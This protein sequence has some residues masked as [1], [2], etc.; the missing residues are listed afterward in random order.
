MTSRVKSLSIAI[1]M[2]LGLSNI[3]NAEDLKTIGNIALE[4]DHKI[5]QLHNNFLISVEK[6]NEIKGMFKP[7]VNLQA[8]GNYSLF[9]EKNGKTYN[10]ALNGSV[11]VNFSYSLYDSSK[12]ALE[13]IQDKQAMI[14]YYNFESYKQ[15][16]LYNVSTVYYETLRNRKI[17]EVDIETKKAMQTQYD[18]IKNM[19]E[20]GLRTKVDLLE[21]RAEL[22][23]AEANLVASENNLQNSLSQLYLYTG[24]Y[25]LNPKDI[26]FNDKKRDF[27]ENGYDY[28][29]KVLDEN[30]F[31]IKKANIAKMIAK[32]N[33]KVA[34]S[35]ND[36]KVAL[37][38]G[39]DSSYNNRAIDE[40]ENSANIGFSV[41]LPVYTSGVN[42]SITKQSQMSYTNS[43]IDLDYTYRQLRPQLKIVINQLESIDRG[44]VS[45]EKTVES[46]K[47][48]L[49][50]IQ[51]SYDVGVRDIVDLLNAN[52][53]Y[54][55]SLK[56]LADAEYNYLLKQN[57]LL[58]LVG[59][60]DIENI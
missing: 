44:I 5:E 45:L 48:S 9:E 54:F 8:A 10:D 31:N 46:T 58:Y 50:A 23:Q 4:K 24:T 29:F 51:G 13:R 27:E 2:T 6:N 26:S 41:T 43:S 47:S 21:V 38:G 22:D 42:D 20:V 36:F 52:T 57:E 39:I 17:V 35:N 55:I 56:N 11:G 32:D 18:Q 1:A 40:F 33:I 14:D 60:L 19:V 15:E 30:N 12:N 25:D 34:Q 28:W 16:L 59:T 3:S 7:Q 49:D 53:Q 37:N